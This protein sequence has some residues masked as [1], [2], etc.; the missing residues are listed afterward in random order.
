MS[1]CTVEMQRIPFRLSNNMVFNLG[2]LVGRV[3]VV[4]DAPL[5]VPLEVNASAYIIINDLKEG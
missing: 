1:A 2:G 3:G 4:S 5:A